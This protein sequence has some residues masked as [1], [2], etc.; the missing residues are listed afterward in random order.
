MRSGIRNSSSPPA[1]K[2]PDYLPAV[3]RFRTDG[4]FPGT[5][6]TCHKRGGCGSEAVA[7][8]QSADCRMT[9]NPSAAV[10]AVEMLQKARKPAVQITRRDRFPAQ[11]RLA[12]LKRRNR[13]RRAGQL[14]YFGLHCEILQSET[15][16]RS[17]KNCRR[18]GSPL[19]SAEPGSRFLFQAAVSLLEGRS[20]SGPVPGAENPR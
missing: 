17:C 2:I 16:E 14:L 9:D 13:N 18:C 1:P 8:K 12:G 7:V 11:N 6:G 3:H 15:G 20:A 19:S 10:S 4:R 5:A